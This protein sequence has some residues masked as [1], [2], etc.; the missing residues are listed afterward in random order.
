MSSVVIY[1]DGSCDPN[2]GP[3][4]WAYV[5]ILSDYEIRA[6]DRVKKTTNNIMEMTAVIEAIK[7]FSEVKSITIY[8]DSQ[9]VL[10]CAQ[11]IWKKKKNLDLWKKYDRIAKGKKIKYIWVK[12]HSGNY[13][14][15]IVDEMA[16]TGQT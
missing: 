5:A 11:G 16:K 8:T 14:N 1:T 9:Y 3:G 4:G 2:P 6:C 13:Y 7:D 12:G 10:N 15:D